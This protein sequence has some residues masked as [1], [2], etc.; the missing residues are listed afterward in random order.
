[1][2]VAGGRGSQA[3]ASLV[4]G[5]AVSKRWR[6]GRLGLALE[7]N[8]VGRRKSPMV[9]EADAD[10]LGSPRGIVAQD[11]TRIEGRRSEANVPNPSMLYTKNVKVC[12]VRG[13]NTGQQR[14]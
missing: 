11:S 1:M 9:V 6:K 7:H 2:Y 13:S 12:L 3:V 8:M 4:S 14:V 5:I 10:E